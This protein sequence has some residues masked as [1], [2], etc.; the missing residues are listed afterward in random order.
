[1]ARAFPDLLI[2]IR[3]LNME[4]E[5][6]TFNRQEKKIQFVRSWVKLE[7][8]ITCDYYKITA[9]SERDAQSWSA[10]RSVRNINIKWTKTMKLIVIVGFC[11]LF[12]TTTVAKKLEEKYVWKE[13][14]FAWPSEEVK[15]EA[16]KSGRYIESHNLPL[17]LEVWKDKMFITVPR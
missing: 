8:V 3:S 16:I 13:L 5:E 7:R 4:K 12:V 2:F 14:E 17:G 9:Y 11:V 10:C 6:V 1:M 15:Q